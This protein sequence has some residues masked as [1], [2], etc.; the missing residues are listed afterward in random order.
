MTAERT[1]LPVAIGPVKMYPVY[2]CEAQQLP[3]LRTPATRCKYPL[4]QIALTATILSPIRK[5]NHCTNAT[6]SR[7]NCLQ[8]FI[9]AVSGQ[10]LSNEPSC[11]R[12]SKFRSTQLLGTPLKVSSKQNCVYSLITAISTIT[13]TIQ[14][15]RLCLKWLS[16]F[17][18]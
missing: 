4:H 14:T 6:A 17:A 7:S 5:L 3:C 10:G 2:S 12:Q 16:H 8:Q 15:G 11:Y 13:M 1:L 18:N 9:S